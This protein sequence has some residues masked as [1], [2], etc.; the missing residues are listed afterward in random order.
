M[1]QFK[2]KIDNLVK[3]D[4]TQMNQLIKNIFYENYKINALIEIYKKSIDEYLEIDPLVE[5][6]NI[7]IYSSEDDTFIIY[8]KF[9]NKDIYK[10]L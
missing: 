2:T 9:K 5:D 7:E 8:I 10:Y 1:F 6:E 4:L 3:E